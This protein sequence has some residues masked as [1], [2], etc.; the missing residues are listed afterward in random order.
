M[1][2]NKLSYRVIK[3]DYEPKFSIELLIDEKPIGVLFETEERKIPYYLFEKDLPSYH[4]DYE[5]KEF[6]II[7]VCS[8]GDAGCGCLGCVLKKE[9]DFVTLQEIFNDGFRFPK[10]LMFRFSREN[11]D[12]VLEEILG[13]VREYKEING[14]TTTS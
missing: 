5:N 14:E 6:H 9:A 13:R 4:S 12:S 11:Y 2:L 7:G 10:D 3:D 8:C 1:K